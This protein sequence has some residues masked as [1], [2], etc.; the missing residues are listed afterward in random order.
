MAALDGV[1][2]TRRIM[3]STPRSSWWLT[4]SVRT[5]AKKAGRNRAVATAA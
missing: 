5:D 2:A 1:E 3:A 4:V